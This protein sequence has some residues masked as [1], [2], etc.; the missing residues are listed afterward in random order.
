[1]D[2]Q[3]EQDYQDNKKKTIEKT[4]EVKIVF[5]KIRIVVPSL[6]YLLRQLPELKLR[7]RGLKF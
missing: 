4:K 1:M 6:I 3:T 2:A 5:I 7:A